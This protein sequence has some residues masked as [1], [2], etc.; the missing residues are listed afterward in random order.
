MGHIPI[1]FL[2]AATA[3]SAR[4]SSQGWRFGASLTRFRSATSVKCLVQNSLTVSV[5]LRLELL[6][7]HQGRVRPVQGGR[8]RTS[9]GRTELARLRVA[10]P[11]EHA[12]ISG[13]SDCTA[14]FFNNLSSERQA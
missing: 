12:V 10:E 13:L 11:S 14:K 7:G 6:R 4:R 9:P 1:A 2:P 3:N 8:A 5:R